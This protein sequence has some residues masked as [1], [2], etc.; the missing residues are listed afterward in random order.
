LAAETKTSELLS[1]K[2][3]PELPPPSVIFHRSSRARS[4]F[5]SLP[6]SVASRHLPHKGG[7]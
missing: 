5:S 2:Q 6:P 1:A 3:G 7:R 4:L